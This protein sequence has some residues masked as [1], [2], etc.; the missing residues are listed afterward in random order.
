MILARMNGVELL[1]ALAHNIINEYILPDL[2]E[3]AEG[4]GVEG[5]E[6]RELVELYEDYT[7]NNAKAKIFGAQ[8]FKQI[9]SIAFRYNFSETEIDDFVMILIE[10]IL[11]RKTWTSFRTIDEGPESFAK[12]FTGAAR[13][14]ARTKARDLAKRR[15]RE[16][17][18]SPVDE[19]DTSNPIERAPDPRR[20]D[21]AD[22][23]LERDVQRDLRKHILRKFRT[24]VHT[25]LFDDWMKALKKH[26][27]GLNVRRH[28]FPPLVD[29]FGLPEKTFYGYMLEMKKVMA[30]FFKDEYGLKLKK[31]SEAPLGFDDIVDRVAYLELRRRMAEWVLPQHPLLRMMWLR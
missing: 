15:S 17:Q 14:Q 8:A 5:M 31:A 10:D 12:W 20:N 3:E 2:R 23:M 16:Q 13:N 27:L 25:R 29:E 24:P 26:G 7:G 6:A 28:L 22:L 19:D 18:M 9:R 21:P 1:N 4:E 30:K 11:R